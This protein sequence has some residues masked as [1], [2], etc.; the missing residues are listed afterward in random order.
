MLKSKYI[1]Q[2]CIIVMA[3]ALI[4]TILFINGEAIGLTPESANPGYVTRLFDKSR[5]HTIDIIIDD[6]DTFLKN[7]TKEKYSPCTMVIDG[8]KF[9]AVG[10]R[11]KGNNSLRLINKYGLDRYSLK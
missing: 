10:L 8:E 4:V 2:I 1:D 9:T 6:W 5:V 3:F 7:A 11:A